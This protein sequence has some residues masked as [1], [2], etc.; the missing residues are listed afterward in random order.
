MT[1]RARSR[2][3]LARLSQPDFRPHG[4]LGDPYSQTIVGAYLPGRGLADRQQHVVPLPDGDRLVIVENRAIAAAP[5]ARVV[6]LA[7][8]LCGSHRSSYLMR[9]GRKCLARGWHVLRVNL[10]NCG[11]GFGQARQLYHSGR[12][13][14]LRAVAHWATSRFPG[15][16]ITLAGF[17]LSGNI[18]LKLAG[19]G[20]DV[21][22]VDGFT[23]VCPPVDLAGAA[24]KL[25]QPR[26]RFFDAYFVKQLRVTAQRLAALES[27]VVSLP[28]HM[29]LRGFDDA[30]TAP[31]S[32]FRDAAD[33]YRRCS[34]LPLLG[35]IT[36]PTLIVAAADD[37]IVD[38]SG[39]EATAP[40]DYL[41]LVVTE[42]GGHLGFLGRGAASWR[43]MDDVLLS[44][45]SQ[46]P[47]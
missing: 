18:V 14:D 43:W 42:R 35:A 36:K 21:G 11:P 39:L 15:S 30:Y 44:W 46:R 47:S 3:V 2:A 17:S 8:G 28:V 34:A 27:Q 1:S 6:V 23:A 45:L 29:T 40:S 33:Y 38:V 24:R 10:R 16:P 12:S 41:D 4:L 22:R 32:G 7:H 5:G 26:N 20:G 19:E 9:L 31:R 25:E 13:E 37:P